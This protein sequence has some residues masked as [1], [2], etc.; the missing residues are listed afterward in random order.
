MDVFVIRGGSNAGDLIYM[1]RLNRRPT[2]DDPRVAHYAY[3][4]ARPD[5]SRIAIIS[6]E[7][8]VLDGGNAPAPILRAYLR[9]IH[10]RIFA[11]GEWIP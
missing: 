1:S 10:G 5:G 11:Q 3:V 9:S 2:E 8:L 7:D 6:H 4:H